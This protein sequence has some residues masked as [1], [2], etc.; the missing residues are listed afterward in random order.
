ML[1]ICELDTRVI[2]STYHDKKANQAGRDAAMSLIARL[3]VEGYGTV[4]SERSDGC[5]A[6]GVA[7]RKDKLVL[8]EQETITFGQHPADGGKPDTR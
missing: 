5:L 7:Y 3:E 2:D 4:V 1:G 6:T 8:L